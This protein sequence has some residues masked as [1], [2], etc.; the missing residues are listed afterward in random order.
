MNTRTSPFKRAK[1]ARL[2]REG[3]SYRTV[4]AETGIAISTLQEWRKRDPDFISLVDG[5]ATL[6]VGPVKL[7]VA[8]DAPIL[9]DGVQ[10]T[11]V[12]LSP[13][14]EVL[15]YAPAA[16]ATHLKAVLVSARNVERIRTEL[17]EGRR[18]TDFSDERMLTLSA[19]ALPAFHDR[20]TAET[21]LTITQ[22]DEAEAF[23]AF[24]ALWK[25]RAGE[26]RDVRTLEERWE[27]QEM[28]L[29]ALTS[30]PHTYA[31]K[32]RKLGETTLAVAYCGFASRFRDS[33]NTRVH[34]F[35]YRERAALQLLADTRYGLD[36]LPAF[37]RLPVKRETMKQVVYDAGDCEQIVEAFPT[38][39]ST[40]VELT[41]THALVD[42]L[43]D[44]PRN[45]QVFASLYPTFAAP[46]CT[47][48]ILTTGKGPADWSATYWRSCKDGDGIHV[49]IFIPA[50]ARPGRD[51]DWLSRTRK[52]MT[53]AD[54]R[55]EYA[56]QEEDVF[57][58]HSG[59][60]FR[61]EDVDT[62]CVYSGPRYAARWAERRIYKP[63]HRYVISWDI[64]GSGAFADASVGTALDITHGV[65]EVLEQRR[66]TSLPYPRLLQEIARMHRDYPS[67]PTCIEANGI[68]Q[69]VL[70]TVDIPKEEL[71]EFSTTNISKNRAISTLEIHLQNNEISWETDACP[72]LAGELKSYQIP[73]DYCV[74][75]CVMSLAIG[76]DCAGQALPT[77]GRILGV[78]TFD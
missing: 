68:G 41:S 40:A 44:I 38:S 75:D 23:K 67:A 49:P 15:G 3:A 10:E 55:V 30:N 35:S 7:Q 51:A 8:Q 17:A 13:T 64:G 65:I 2:F 36:N 18:P 9:D 58:G 43:A 48:T 66:F 37:L 20:K 19:D 1:A 52:Q 46:G 60:L 31:A 61:S 21:L 76:L 4:R 5:K 34:E 25:F 16:N 27:S 6:H 63:K 78:L 11:Y 54:F 73:D 56:M 29:D 26:T 28:L 77:P 45:Q 50:T 22:P 71:I 53:Q 33:G 70:G 12:W 74:T 14:A 62:C 32:A 72:N 69:A 42:E 59:S 24:C 57:A 39:D 47:S